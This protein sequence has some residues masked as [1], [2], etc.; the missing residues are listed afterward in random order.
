MLEL[1]YNGG[2][3]WNLLW[4]LSSSCQYATLIHESRQNVRYS[5]RKYARVS[6]IAA[7]HHWGKLSNDAVAIPAASL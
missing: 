4:C 3:F 5:R 7:W 6:H 2:C 1:F